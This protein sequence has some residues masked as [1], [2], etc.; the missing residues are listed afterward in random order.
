MIDEASFGLPLNVNELAHDDG[1]YRELSADARLD[2]QR[3]LDRAGARLMA[4]RI[5]MHSMLL[6]GAAATT[7]MYTTS[8]GDVVV[9]TS[10]G[11]VGG[12]RWPIGSV[13]EKL[14][15]S[16]PVSIVLVPTGREP[17]FDLPLLTG[18]FQQE[19][20]RAV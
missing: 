13:A 5:G 4:K 7:I 17:E 6:S 14:I 19:P 20:I 11:R 2:A 9:M 1:L 16:G 8:P 10:R 15:D 18:I 3:T 12:R